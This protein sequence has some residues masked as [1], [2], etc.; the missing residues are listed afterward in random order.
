[1]GALL[2]PCACAAPLSRHFRPGPPSWKRLRRWRCLKLGEKPSG[3]CFSKDK[4]TQVNLLPRT[5]N[6]LLEKLWNNEPKNI[7]TLLEEHIHDSW[8]Q[9]VMLLL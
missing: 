9:C 8:E 3:A 7:L 4:E 6:R 2:A 5:Q 1:M